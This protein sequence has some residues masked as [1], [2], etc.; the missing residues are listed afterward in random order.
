V[1]PL[2]GAAGFGGEI[3]S[4]V[5]QALRDADAYKGGGVHAIVVENMHDTPYLKG[6]VHPET[7]AAM[8]VVARAVKAQTKLPLGVQLLAGAN[9][10]ALGVAVAAGADFI[11]VEGFVFAHIG[12]EGI[13]ESCAA[14]L[15]RK[16]AELKAS[17][18]K[19]FADIKKKHSAHA[20]TSDVT[21]AE[22][23][24]NAEF[25][26]ADGVIVTGSSTGYAP[27]PADVR[28]VRDAVSCEVLVGSGMVM[29]N[30]NMF[31]PHCDALIVGSSLKKDGRWQNAVDQK[32]VEELM[33]VAA[34]FI[35]KSTV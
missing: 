4:I 23:A 11:R 22:T 3:E 27:D 21:L 17:R 10:E 13:H 1:P 2:P 31:L 6:F 12:D 20:I 35:S 7:T 24:V 5:E 8:A 32:R 16:R 26:R 9:L 29:Q 18:I 14:V 33:S 25:F 30:I 28:D 34:K 19:I 15:V